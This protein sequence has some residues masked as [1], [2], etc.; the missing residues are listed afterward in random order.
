MA[1]NAERAAHDL[2]ARHAVAAPPVP[3]D[4]IAAAEGISV[5][6]EPF[7]DDE[8]SGVLLR[9][10]DRTMII[11]NA[12]NAVVRQRFTIAHEIGHFTLHRGT[13]YLD[14]RARVNFRDG[15]SSMATDQEEI[16]ANSFAAALLMPTKW[17]RTAFE[18]TV[19]NSPV[20]SEEELAGLL[21]GRFVVSRQAMLFRLIYLGLI[22]AP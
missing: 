12:A 19:R 7:R 3:V 16:E 14:G 15:L 17:V 4:K 20:G 6:Q 8:V 11:V 21:A 22:A 13:V 10:P 1:S 5:V 9:E 2:L 18:T